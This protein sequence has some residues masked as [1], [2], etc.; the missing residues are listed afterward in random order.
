MRFA[1]SLDKATD[2]RWKY[3]YVIFIA[4]KRQ[5]RL[6]LIR[7]LPTCTLLEF[8]VCSLRLESRCALI[9]VVGSDV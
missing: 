3:S 1:C 8:R 7:P 9:K 4:F 6:K 5:Q 2:T